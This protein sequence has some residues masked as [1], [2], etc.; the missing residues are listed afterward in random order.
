MMK[1]EA[2]QKS[3]LLPYEIIRAA[4][5]GSTS[6][7]NTVLKHYQN[8]IHSLAVKDHI[9]SLGNVYSY[10]DHETI[11]RL[12]AKLTSKILLFRAEE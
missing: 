7:I 9:D 5:K 11:L 6:A 8:Y 3:N 2:K 12:E 4:S 10:P 1:G